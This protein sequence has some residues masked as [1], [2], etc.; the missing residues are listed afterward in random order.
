VVV[1]EEADMAAPAVAITAV[2]VI[3]LTEEEDIIPMEVSVTEE[4]VLV[5]MAVAI[6]AVIMAVHM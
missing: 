4:E 2:A 5:I 1:A 3:T 6:T